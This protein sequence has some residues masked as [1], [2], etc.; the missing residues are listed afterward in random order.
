MEQ[1]NQA[2]KNG[3][4][5]KLDGEGESVSS[6]SKKYLIK[7]IVILILVL[8]ILAIAG[9]IYS[10]LFAEKDENQLFL[11]MNTEILEDKNAKEVEVDRELDSDQDK[12]PDYLEKILGTSESNP[13]TDGDGY[14]DFD[15]I[16][17]W[18]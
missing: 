12:L 11:E 13:D 10:S 14:S 3:A 7:K 16:K 15:E 6:G 18:L 9:F 4:E 8:S 5:I 17:K 1:N 2:N